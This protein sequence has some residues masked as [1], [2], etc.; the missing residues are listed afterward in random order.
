MDKKVIQARDVMHEKHLELDGMATVRQAL[1]NY[2]GGKLTEAAPC[3]ESV[4]HG[5]G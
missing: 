5:H 4:E 3:D 2:L 1:E